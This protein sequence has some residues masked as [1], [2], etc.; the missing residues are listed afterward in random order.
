MPP[1][2][3]EG[4]CVYQPILEE[5]IKASFVSA[6]TKNRA[7]TCAANHASHC[8]VQASI[9]LSDKDLKGNTFW[10]K[11]IFFQIL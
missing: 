9:S 1:C 5:P 8:A 10:L 2:H 7:Y 11:S 3:Q 6:F 4:P